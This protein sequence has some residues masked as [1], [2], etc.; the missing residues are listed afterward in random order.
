MEKT[1]EARECMA[2]DAKQIDLCMVEVTEACER[3][4]IQKKKVEQ[5]KEDRLRI[6][7]LERI[8]TIGKQK[9]TEYP[10]NPDLEKRQEEIE[11]E[12]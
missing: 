1:A 7:V 5:E 11:Q 2:N 12:K 10:D 8:V 4:A 3:M 9:I 6:A